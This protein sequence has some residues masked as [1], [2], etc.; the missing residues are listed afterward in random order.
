MSPKARARPPFT[1][2]LILAW[3]D[4]HHAATGRWPTGDLTPVAAEPGLRWRWVDHALG[5]GGRG[6][7][8]SDSLVRPGRAVTPARRTQRLPTWT[9]NRTGFRTGKPTSLPINGV[10]RSRYW[11]VGTLPGPSFNGWTA[12]ANQR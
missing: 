8:G 3:A 9:K 6:L 2:D 11:G 4:A 12:Q 5:S 1:P 10:S 7:P